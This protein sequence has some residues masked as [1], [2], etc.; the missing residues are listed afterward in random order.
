MSKKICILDYGLG[1]IL[2]LK[3]ALNFLGFDN[4]FYSEKE[5]KNF[6]CLVIPG[7]GAFSQAVDLI[8]KNLKKLIDKSANE[9]LFIIGICLGMQILFKRGFENGE[10]K[11]LEY[12]DGNVIKIEGKDITKLPHIGWKRT[13]FSKDLF[14][15]SIQVKNYIMFIHMNAFQK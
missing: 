1:N 12:L 8:K 9:G 13:N 15:I 14:L 3:N 10:S 7:V 11:G 4:F 5:K 6:D 2:S